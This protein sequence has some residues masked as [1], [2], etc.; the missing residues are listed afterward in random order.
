MLIILKAILLLLEKYFNDRRKELLEIK[1]AAE[2]DQ[3]LCTHTVTLMLRKSER[4]LFN[5]VRTEKLICK[6]IGKANFYLESSVLKLKER[7]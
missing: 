1:Q 2:K 7:M 6:K 5:Y 4:T 3:W